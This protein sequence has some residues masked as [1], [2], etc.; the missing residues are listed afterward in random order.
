MIRDSRKLTFRFNYI[1]TLEIGCQTEKIREK[2]MI[3]VSKTAFHVEGKVYNK[4]QSLSFIWSL[5]FKRFIGK[6]S[7]T[8]SWFIHKL[9]INPLE[10]FFGVVYWVENNLSLRAY[11]REKS[12]LLEFF[13]RLKKWGRVNF[14]RR[15]YFTEKGKNVPQYEHWVI[16]WCHI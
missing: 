4:V 13:T 2:K 6:K 10:Y 3:T 9:S 7:R 5:L 8:L 11:D 1:L 14:E 16:N 12:S 15:L